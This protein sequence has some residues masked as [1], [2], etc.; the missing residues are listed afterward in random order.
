MNLD[1]CIYKEKQA[2]FKN[3]YLC[4]YKIVINSL[5]MHFGVT[6][7]HAGVG[8]ENLIIFTYKNHLDRFYRI[9]KQFI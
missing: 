2:Y 5:E 9:R 1:L 6:R 7:Q 8:H 3:K 4:N